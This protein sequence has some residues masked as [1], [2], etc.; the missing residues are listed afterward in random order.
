MLKI[1]TMVAGLSFVAG[2]A[3]AYDLVIDT[4]DDAV[5]TTVL[6]S[7]VG[8]PLT[9]DDTGLAGVLGG[10]RSIFVEGVLSVQ[11]GVI[12]S[13]GIFDYMSIGTGF[14][15]ATY[16]ADGSGFGNAIACAQEIEIAYQL[17][18]ASAQGEGTG[19]AEIT[20]ALTGGATVAVSRPIT[21][22]AGT[23]SYP[24]ADFAGVD[25]TN[26]T[27]IAMTVD[28]TA[29]DSADLAVDSIRAVGCDVLP[30]PSPAMGPA[31]L[32]FGSLVLAGL[33][34]LGVARRRRI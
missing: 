29:S 11:A 34:L 20:V 6:T 3:L 19:Q 5:N 14:A 28:G 31:A 16:D 26:L 30:S 25:L 21:A 4:F 1:L 17:A 2:S 33:G 13:A 32:G 10:S 23:L 22:T 12:E 24:I 15:E 9:A 18:D 7:N 27:E 8:V